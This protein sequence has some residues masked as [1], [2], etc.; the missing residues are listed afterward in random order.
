[1]MHVPSPV[2]EAVDGMFLVML[3]FMLGTTSRYAVRTTGRSTRHGDWGPWKWSVEAK[4]AWALAIIFFGLILRVG[5][6]W[7]LRHAAGHGLHWEALVAAGPAV[8]LV[9]TLLTTWGSVCWIRTIIPLQCGPWGWT[10][11]AI[12]AAAFG[13]Y[14]AA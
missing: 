11:A 10:A 8:V 9:S 12:F 14:M 5:A 7:S 3:I 13:V 6:H 4:A 1:M 2:L